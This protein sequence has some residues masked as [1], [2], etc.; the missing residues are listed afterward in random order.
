[1]KKT[2][3]IIEDEKDFA[4]VYGNIL[5]KEDFNVLMAADGTTGKE[6]ALKEQPDLILLD[7]LLPGVDG[8]ALLR[9]LRARGLKSEVIIL[10]ASPILHVQ[11]GVRLGIYAYLNKALSTPKEIVA[12]IREA[13]KRKEAAK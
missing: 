4:T 3:L 9:E 12:L 10:T 13:L 5:K 11:E 8:I 1:M 7:I 2:V 6:L